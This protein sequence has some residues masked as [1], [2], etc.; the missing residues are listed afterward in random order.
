MV[1]CPNVENPTTALELGHRLAGAVT[2]DIAIGNQPVELRAS[3]GVAWTDQPLVAD[4]FVAQA[5]AAMYESKQTRQSTARLWDPPPTP[6]VVG[7]SD[8]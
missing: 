3:I 6:L 7:A 5:D 8:R 2:A 1:I 4:A